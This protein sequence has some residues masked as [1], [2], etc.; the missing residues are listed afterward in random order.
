MFKL[1]KQ[2]CVVAGIASVFVLNACSMMPDRADASPPVVMLTGAQEVPP[3]TSG[4]TGKSTI[5][6]ASDKSVTGSVTYTGMTATASHIHQGAKGASGPPIVPLTKTSG[7][8][9]V[10]P[11]NSKLTDAQYASYLAGNL[12]VNVHSAALPGGEIRAQLAPR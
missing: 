4:A 5:Q 10:V 2:V 8:G 6:V 7:S 3:N 9:F 11:P 12:Y 1:I